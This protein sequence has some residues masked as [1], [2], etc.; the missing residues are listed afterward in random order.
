MIEV[1]WFFIFL[2]LVSVFAWP[3]WPNSKNVGS[4]VAAA[5]SVMRPV[6]WQDR[7][8]SVCCN[9]FGWGRLPLIC[10]GKRSRCRRTEAALAAGIEPMAIPS[11]RPALSREGR[12][13]SEC[14]SLS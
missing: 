6:V 14:R 9:F 1:F 5:D 13:G 10:C 11:R 8:F 3:T 12:A 4:I 2:L 7:M